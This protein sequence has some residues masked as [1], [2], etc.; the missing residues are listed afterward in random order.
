MSCCF[1]FPGCFCLNDEEQMVLEGLTGKT[2]INGPGCNCVGPCWNGKK[3]RGQQLAANQFIKIINEIDGNVDI[4]P[5]PMLYFLDA[6]ET[7]VDN[8][9]NDAL[10]LD[11]TEYVIVTNTLTGEVEQKVGPM[12]FV[13]GPYETRTE[14]LRC[15]ALKHNEFV[16]VVDHNSGRL[17][18]VKGED[19][20]FLSPFEEFLKHNGKIVREAV[21]IDEHTAVLVRNTETGQLYLFKEQMLF[22]PTIHEE[23]VEVQKKIVLKDHETAIIKDKDGNFHFMSGATGPRCSKSAEQAIVDSLN[24]SHKKKKKKKGEDVDYD[25]AIAEY[26][27][28]IFGVEAGGRAFFVP[29]Y[30]E[31]LALEWTISIDKTKVIKTIDSRPHFMEYTFVCRTSDNVELVIDVTFFWQ[32]IDVEAMIEQTD[33]APGDIC[34]HARSVTIQAVSTLTMEEFMMNFNSILSKAILESDDEFYDQRGCVIHTVEV[35]SFHC[36]DPGTE[37]VLQE[38]IKERTDRMNRLQKQES[39]NEVRLFKMKGDIEEEKLHGELLKIRHSHHRTEAAME[40]EAEADQLRM[41]LQG[42]EDVQDPVKFEFW[43]TLRKLDSIRAV[44]QGGGNFYYTPNDV[45]LSIGT[46]GNPFEG[47][48]RNRKKNEEENLVS[49]D[50]KGKRDLEKKYNFSKF[51]NND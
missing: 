30:C 20:V 27:R 14:K 10:P 50:L 38:I 46:F 11:K 23:I 36:K 33:D 9:V 31:M 34:A 44:S 49:R 24:L 37:D 40:G 43:S 29:P 15:V 12:L 39:E 2:V 42:L 4:V 19:T 35:K 7:V 51:T 5:G 41:F 45:D 32:V 6:Y 48:R 13:P 28:N 17:R 8:K 1:I 3:R 21:N 18:I 22:F 25:I 26:Y 16:K 47:G